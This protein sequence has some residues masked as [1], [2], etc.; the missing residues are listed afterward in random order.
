LLREPVSV[1]ELL[2]L[3]DNTGNV[4]GV[5]TNEIG[6]VKQAVDSQIP[7]LSGGCLLYGARGSC[8]AH[9]AAAVLAF[10]FLKVF[11]G[12]CF[13]ACNALEDKIDVVYDAKFL[14]LLRVVLLVCFRLRCFAF[15]S[16]SNF[17][18]L[19]FS[20]LLCFNLLLKVC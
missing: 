20:C 16:T 17:F 9:E 7:L 6:M 19:C 12:V 3:I 11:L 5:N 15:D 4:G 18:F 1:E 13:L 10:C 2:V 14:V 8:E